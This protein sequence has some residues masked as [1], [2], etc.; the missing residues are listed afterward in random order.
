MA[1]VADAYEELGYH[2]LID[3]PGR[4]A[5]EGPRLEQWLAGA[6]SRRLL[7]LGCAT[8]EHG[9]WLVERSF[10]VVGV[11]RSAALLDEARGRGLPP[12]LELAEGDLL[13]LESVVTGPFGGALCLGNTLP[14][15]TT[16]EELAGFLA[17]LRRLLLPGGV[18]VLQLLGY[19]RILDGGVRALPVAVRP[20]EDGEAAFVRL[21]TP[22]PDGMV[23]F[24][25]TRLSLL[26][27]RDPPVTVV[28]SRRVQLRG[29]RRAELVA[30]LGTAGF[31]TVE[32]LGAFDGSAWQP[33]S[34]D[35]ILVAR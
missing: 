6:P 17:A 35:L 9:R 26:P 31:E 18:L 27:D 1:S 33:S 28:T 15:V 4:L 12:G 16:D 11:D 19:D 25:P 14:H 32:A 22:R 34:S 7:E 30:A 23:S 13:D 2:R 10:T 3:W 21:M 5:R 24:F 8:A 20:A 29:W